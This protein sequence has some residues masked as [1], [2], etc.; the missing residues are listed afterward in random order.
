LSW[1]GAFTRARHAAPLEVSEAY[2]R[3]APVYPGHAANELMRLEQEAMIRLLP[4]VAGRD[5]LDVG[6]GGGRYLRLLRETGARLCVGV[7][8]TPAML[9][10]CRELPAGLACA[11]LPLL[12]LRDAAFDVAL[13]GLVLGHL[14]DLEAALREIARVLRAGGRLLYSDVHAEGAARG[15][16]RT[17]VAADGREYAVR[18]FVHSLSA[19]HRALEAAGFELEAVEEPRVRETAAWRGTRAVFVARA[20]RLGA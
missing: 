5:G 7:D 2:E 19:H 6:C 4:D 13:C 9:A 3:W 16:R 8:S 15:W 1:L 12:P 17:F 20:R 10:R 11:R 14:E 18:H